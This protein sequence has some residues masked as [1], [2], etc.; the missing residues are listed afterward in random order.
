MAK[1]VIGQSVHR[2]DA[3]GKVTGATQY[4]GDL[5]RP[6]QAH[7]KILFAGRPHAIVRRLEMAAAKG[8][9]G[10]LAVFTARDVPVNEYGLIMPDQPV[11]CGPGSAKPFADRVRF[12]GDQ[13]ALVVADS[14]HQAKDAAELIEVDYEALEA[15]VECGRADGAGSAV[16][17]EV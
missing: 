14:V 17:D 5:H 8:T 15:V 7:M 3:L 12:V 13:V 1:S 10:V 9:P 11:L 16:H 4:P 6:D 2:V